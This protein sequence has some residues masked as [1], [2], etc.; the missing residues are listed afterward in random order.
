MISQLKSGFQRLVNALGYRLERLDAPP[1]PH[2]LELDPSYANIIER[3]KPF[4]MTSCERIASLVDAVRHVSQNGITGAI[5]ECG[6]WR[7][8]SMMAAALALLE[9]GEA[10]DLYLFDTY[11]GM[12]EPTERDFDHRGDMAEAIYKDMLEGDES[13]WCRAGLEDVTANLKSTGYPPQKCHFIKGDVLETVPVAAPAEIAILRLD[14][15]WYESTRH[16]M[17]HLFPR[18]QPGGI[19]IVDDYGHWNGCRQ[20]VDE[21]FG[22]TR[23][24]MFSIDYCGRAMVKQP[25][26]GQVSR[27]QVREAKRAGAHE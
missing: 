11:A 21:Y 17:A 18:L 7:G 22:E 3:V 10:R 27:G 23:P 24:F 2:R 16:E 4:T 1:P 8:G 20:A 25:E 13:G 14:T 6:V 19:L 5:V 26:A 12:T 15:D 9:A